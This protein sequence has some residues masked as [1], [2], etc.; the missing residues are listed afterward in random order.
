MKKNQYRQANKATSGTDLLVY[1]PKI[2]DA[3]RLPA[4]R[5]KWRSGN[6]GGGGN[7]NHLYHW[8]EDFQNAV[9]GGYFSSCSFK[10]KD[11]SAF[12]SSRQINAGA[13]T[14]VFNIYVL[15]KIFSKT[16]IVAPGWS[17]SRSVGPRV[18][19][20]AARMAKLKDND[21][22]PLLMSWP[23]KQRCLDGD[24]VR[25]VRCTGKSKNDSGLALFVK[26]EPERWILCPGDASF[27]R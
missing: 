15:D 3:L 20:F 26:K 17:A 24:S 8:A 6:S 21:G 12:V 1:A 27:S 10:A 22:E 7:G 13:E 23:E 2:K 14:G 5:Q 18:R 4:S 16:K 9:I 19:A 25:L 11:N